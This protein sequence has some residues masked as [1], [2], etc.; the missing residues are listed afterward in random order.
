ME[1]RVHQRREGWTRRRAVVAGAGAAM[2][3]TGLGALRST[4]RAG[5][6]AVLGD[7]RAGLLV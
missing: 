2:L 3:A 7:Q 5:A 4:R 6:Q 1:P